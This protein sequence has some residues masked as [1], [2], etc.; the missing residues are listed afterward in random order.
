MSNVGGMPEGATPLYSNDGGL[1]D[2]IRGLESKVYSMAREAGNSPTNLRESI[3]AFTAAVDWDERWIQCL[4][5]F[6]IVVWV[7]TIST[8]RAFFW[9]CTTFLIICI[10]V[11]GAETLNAYAHLHWRSFSKQDYFDSHGIFVG[12]MF[13]GPLLLL[14]LFQM[15]NFLVIASNLL[16]EVKRNELRSQ[17]AS[18]KT[19]KQ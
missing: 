1:D 2:M 12:V 14:A 11:W 15:V 3:E 19:K 8:R 10:L 13:S 5:V 9:Q 18:K 4:L 17:I 6:H 16:V 7:V